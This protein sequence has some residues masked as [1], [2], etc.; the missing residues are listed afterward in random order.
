M[1][2]RASSAARTAPP[3]M[4]QIEEESAPIV[5]SRKAEDLADL[6][7]RGAAAIADDG[8]GDAGVVAS[9]VLVDVLD[10]LLA[11]LVLEIDIDVGRLAAIRG[12]EALEQQAAFARIDLGDA[13]A[14]ADRRVR[15]RAA[16]LAKNVL[17]A[18][19]SDDVDA[20]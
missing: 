10:H 19:V 12:D 7:D 9:V 16:A 13:Q 20:R 14:V 11:P 8:A 17:A 1:P 3:P 6:A 5:S 4:P 2:A 18:G 15:R